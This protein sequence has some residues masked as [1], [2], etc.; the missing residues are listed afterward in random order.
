MRPR[1]CLYLL[2]E[3]GD[4]IAAQHGT[5]T[6][7]FGRLAAPHDIELVPVEGRVDGPRVDAGAFAGFV[8]TGSACSL[9]ERTPWMD[10]AIELVRSAHDRGTPLLGVCFGH[11]MIAEAFGGRVER[12][13][14][15]WEISTCAIETTPAGAADPLFAGLPPG[16]EVNLSHQDAAGDRLPPAVRVLATNPKTVA[17]AVAVGET[18]RGVQFHP[19]FS[20]PVMRAY[21]RKRYELLLADAT[22]RGA[23][24]TEHP[25]ALLARAR[26]CDHGRAVFANFIT[27]FVLNA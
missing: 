7:W 21:V 9:T 6:D 16:L 25:D 1:V 18:T 23:L 10:R 2:G 11:Q 22:E 26:D 17:Q 27:R 3:A 13:P 12:N 8:L 5:Y 15:G 24:D 14:Q 20:G 4:D 19:E